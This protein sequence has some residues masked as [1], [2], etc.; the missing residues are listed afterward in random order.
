MQPHHHISIEQI[1]VHVIAICSLLHT[2]LP[3]W[4]VLDDFPIAQKY[5][6]V[7]VYTIGYMALSGRSTV[8]RSISTGNP[9]GP[10]A[11][12]P[13]PGPNL[14]TETKPPTVS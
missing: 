12:A 4:E 14:L 3:P 9:T 13:A 8:Y 11:N 1:A 2:F 10:N 5:Y 7:F 6:K